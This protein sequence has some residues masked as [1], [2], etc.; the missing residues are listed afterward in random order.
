MRLSGRVVAITGASAGI[1]R[2]TAEICAHEGAAVALCARR[3]DQ[4]RK[5]AD[6]VTGRGGRALAIQADVTSEA[7]M[8]LFVSRTVETFG[9]L[10]VMICNAGAGFHGTLAETTPEIARRL[11]DVNVL[12]TIYAAHAAHT[13]FARQGSGHLIA[14]SSVAGRR[15]VGGMSLY[16]A[17]KFAQVGFIEGLRTEF[18]GTNLRASVIYPISTPTE[19]HSSMIRDFG[20]AVEGDGPRQT[21]D[22][23]ATAIVEC[24]IA[25]KAEVYLYRKAW[26]LAV[27][28]VVAPERADRL[29]Q[30]YARGRVTGPPRSFPDGGERK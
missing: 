8:R 25:P 9:G 27:L 26:W 20:H 2:A 15:G 5:F 11:I 29:M 18:L 22:E 1:G 12:G 21:V 16:S 17:S 23:V 10:D 14:V 4:L 30:K 28:S 3:I 13:V 6:T 19:F 7:D 24:I